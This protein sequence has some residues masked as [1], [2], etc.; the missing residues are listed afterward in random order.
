MSAE[1]KR[2]SYLDEADHGFQPRPFHSSQVGAASLAPSY[3]TASV[4]APPAHASDLSYPASSHSGVLAPPT[5]HTASGGGSSTSTGPASNAYRHDWAEETA[6]LA[7]SDS[8]S[9]VG[10]RE[11]RG[12]QHKPQQSVAGLSYVDEEGGYHRDSLW[13]PVGDGYGVERDDDDGRAGLVAGAAGM[14]GRTRSM[15]GD[16]EVGKEDGFDS[17]S[18]RVSFNQM[19]AFLSKV[20]LWLVLAIALPW[21]T[22]MCVA[23]TRL[24]QRSGT[25]RQWSCPLRPNPVPE[26]ARERR[27]RWRQVPPRA[28]DREQAYAQ[29]PPLF[30]SQYCA[31]S[32]F[33]DRSWDRKAAPA[34]G[35]LDVVSR[36]GRGDGVRA[37][38]Q[39]AAHG[40]PHRHQAD[41]QLDE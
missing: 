30:K 29:R 33:L 16:G 2:S 38:A 7:P 15:G 26:G 8:A 20:C 12:Q 21:L 3:H 22:R 28:A 39:P 23:A 36:H 17:R 41:V 1:V 25:V 9:A 27:P 4:P 6:S 11:T 37:R 13:K 31:Y 10:S 18:K 14:A 24:R 34:L 32:D 19:G 5:A 35:R 40:I